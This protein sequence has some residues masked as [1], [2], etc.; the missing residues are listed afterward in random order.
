M[1]RAPRRPPLVL[2]EARRDFS[3]ELIRA[4]WPRGRRAGVRQLAGALLFE[5]SANLAGQSIDMRVGTL[6][7]A[8]TFDAR[9]GNCGGGLGV[10]QGGVYELVVGH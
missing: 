1:A 5:V 9:G 10:S 4:Q 3:S 2:L 7:C 8:P 6:A